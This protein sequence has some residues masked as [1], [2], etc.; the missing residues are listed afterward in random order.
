MSR[1]F[2]SAPRSASRSSESF[3]A[4]RHV[5]L[6]VDW[7]L[8]IS[9][10]SPFYI[11]CNYLTIR[12]FMVIDSKSKKNKH[13]HVTV[14][15][16]EKVW[17]NLTH[18]E[19]LA[20][21]YP[22]SNKWFTHFRL[23]GFPPQKLA[24]QHGI[25]YLRGREEIESWKV[26]FPSVFSSWWFVYVFP[27]SLFLYYTSL[28]GVF[29]PTQL[30]NMLKSQNG[31]V[32]L[33]QFSGWK[34]PKN[35]LS[36]QFPVLWCL[37]ETLLLVFCQLLLIFCWTTNSR[38]EWRLLRESLQQGLKVAGFFH[39]CKACQS[40]HVALWNSVAHLIWWTHLP[41]PQK[42]R[43][44]KKKWDLQNF[45]SSPNFPAF[46]FVSE[47]VGPSG[48]LPQFSRAPLWF[49]FPADV[50]WIG[51]PKKPKKRHK[52]GWKW[53]GLKGDFYTW[54]CGYCWW[55]RNPKANHRW[56]FGQNLVNHWIN[57]QQ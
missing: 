16:K 25:F 10:K 1:R 17:K 43:F 33:P 48:P 55:F 7:S 32:H 51:R 46:F 22:N 21:I 53:G 36:C 13:Y 40:K 47:R 44:E 18:M 27:T 19:K 50:G 57:Y 15:P 8:L 54:Y 31:W 3:H 45:I 5:T 4:S 49:P 28:V 26:G 6:A 35:S 12:C 30:K 24:F 42:Q 34:C 20:P 37:L 29:S 41:K 56:D 38:L 52:A 11:Q 39:D 14:H 9:N 23:N 2:F